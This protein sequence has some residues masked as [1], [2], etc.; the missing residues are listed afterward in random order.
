MKA[1]EGRLILGVEKDSPVEEVEERF[2]RLFRANDPENG[3]SFYLQ[4]KVYRAHESILRELGIDP[5]TSSQ[6]SSESKDSS[7]SSSSKPPPSNSG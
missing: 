2:K 6:T 4:S 5:E 1:D 7:T 3:G